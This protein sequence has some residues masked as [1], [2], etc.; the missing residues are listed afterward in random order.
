M[1]NNI[2]EHCQN[3]YQSITNDDQYS[4]LKVV[5][6]ITYECNAWFYLKKNG[7]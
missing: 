5:K 2:C 4:D 1:H 7:D 3:K 6:D